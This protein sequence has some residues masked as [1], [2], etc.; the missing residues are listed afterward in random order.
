VLLPHPV[1]SPADRKEGPDIAFLWPPVKDYMTLRLLAKS[2]YL[3]KFIN[4]IPLS[5]AT[6]EECMVHLQPLEYKDL[7]LLKATRRV[8]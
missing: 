8:P 5:N 6:P 2:Q 4:D 7:K 1:L 3:P